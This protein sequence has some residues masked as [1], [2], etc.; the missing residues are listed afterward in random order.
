MAK[1]IHTM[2]NAEPAAAEAAQ[3]T[4]SRPHVRSGSGAAI[5]AV[6]PIGGSRTAAQ[7]EALARKAAGEP[8]AES[9]LAP[10]DRPKQQPRRS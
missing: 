9:E 8:V 10:C 5:P 1:D 2:P 4:P 6:P 7:A 3:S